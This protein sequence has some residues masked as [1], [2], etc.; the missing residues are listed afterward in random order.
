MAG[1]AK[2]MVWVALLAFVLAVVVSFTGPI[3]GI[4]AEAL[5]RACTNLALIGIGL[6]LGEKA[7]SSATA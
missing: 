4:P 7:A 2:L 3:M 5:S 1:F 6:M